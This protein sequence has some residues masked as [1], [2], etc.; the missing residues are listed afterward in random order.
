MAEELKIDALTPEKGI[1]IAEVACGHEGSFDRVKQL[2]DVVEKSDTDIIKYQ[3]FYT[4]E[5]AQKGEKEWDIFKGLTFD[6]S[7]WEKVV[8]Y[9]KSAG[10]SIMADVYGYK[11][12]QLARDLKVDGFKIHSEDLLNSFFIRDVFSR[13]CSSVTLP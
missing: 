3:I 13:A 4:S 7:G 6:E 12:F 10:L 8:E 5:R 9:S 11:S 2:V 1:V